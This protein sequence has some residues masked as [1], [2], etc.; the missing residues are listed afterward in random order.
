MSFYD[1][2][3]HFADGYGLAA[4]VALYLVL[5]AWPFLP[6]AKGRTSEAAN[7][8]FEEDDDGR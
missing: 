6:H 3:R 4:M 5:I 2:L 8:I 1:Q 7:S